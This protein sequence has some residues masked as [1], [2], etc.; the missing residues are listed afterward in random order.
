MKLSRLKFILPVTALL[1]LFS[2]GGKSDSD[3]KTIIQLLEAVQEIK[4]PEI[5]NI[6]LKETVS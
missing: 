4:N 6:V 5:E 2:C 1:F 3:L